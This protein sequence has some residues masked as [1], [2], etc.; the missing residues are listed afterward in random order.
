MR[1]I[2]YWLGRGVA[3]VAWQAKPRHGLDLV[4]GH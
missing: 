4:A 2:V 3:P 1:K